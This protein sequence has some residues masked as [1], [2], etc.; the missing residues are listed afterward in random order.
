MPEQTTQHTPGPWRYD[1][2]DGH[3]YATSEASPLPAPARVCDPHADDIDIDEREANARLIA[4]APDLLAALRDIY[5]AARSRDATMGD[6]I[7]LFEARRELRESCER[8][9]A[10]IAAA[11]GN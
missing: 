4:A 3:I 5:R 7:D 9:R 10:A 1:P 11:T 8:A 6:Q 2:V